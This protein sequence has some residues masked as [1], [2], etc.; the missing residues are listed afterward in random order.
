[1][2]PVVCITGSS[3]TYSPKRKKNEGESRG[4]ILRLSGSLEGGKRR[5]THRIIYGPGIPEAPS[6][7]DMI[8][9]TVQEVAPSLARPNNRRT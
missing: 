8:V 4:W 2:V 6:P 9:T 3:V 5:I 1:M 7:F